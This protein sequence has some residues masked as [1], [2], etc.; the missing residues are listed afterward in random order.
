MY[1][2]FNIAYAFMGESDMKLGAAIKEAAE[3]SVQNK[4]L[5]NY[6]KVGDGTYPLTGL[7]SRKRSFS[8]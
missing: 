8:K 3:G 7:L 4:K 1:H 5:L 6:E 2:S